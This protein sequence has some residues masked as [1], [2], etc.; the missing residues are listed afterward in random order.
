MRIIIVGV[1]CVFV[2]V[3]FEGLGGYEVL[4]LNVCLWSEDGKIGFGVGLFWSGWVGGVGFVV[5]SGLM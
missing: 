5:L 2:I 4:N 3:F 1:L